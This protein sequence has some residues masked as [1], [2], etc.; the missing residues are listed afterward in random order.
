LLAE[1][2]DDISNLEVPKDEPAP[3]VKEEAA[4]TPTPAPQPPKADPPK[5]STSSSA[6]PSAPPTAAHVEHSSPLFPSVQRL[7]A[8]NNISDPSV[9][10]GTGIRGMVTKGDVLTYLG[11]ASG[12]LGTFKDVA[13]AAEKVDKPAEIKPLDGDAIRRLIVTTMH[14]KALKARNPPLQGIANASFDSIIADYL[15]PQASTTTSTPSRLPPPKSQSSID[16]L[17]G[18][19]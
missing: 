1:E 2:G 12:P 9:V 8:L 11:K 16:Y 13:N 6:G 19:I 7:L 15:P 17:D 18:L 4:P 10:K 3:P 14:Q 5:P